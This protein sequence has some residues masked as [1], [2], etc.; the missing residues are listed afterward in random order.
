MQVSGI[1]QP[2]VFWFKDS[3]PLISSYDCK[4]L[5]DGDEHTLL[6]LEVFP[7]DASVYSC[8]AKND[9]G[10][11]TSSASLT[12]EGILSCRGIEM[13]ESILFFP[14]RFLLGF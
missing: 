3:Q 9:Y 4:I 11:V 1:P 12:V 7:E 8:E 10:V 13:L 2:Q 6:M 14:I 5:H